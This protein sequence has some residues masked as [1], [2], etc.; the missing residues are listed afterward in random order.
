MEDEMGK[1][2]VMET[3]TQE[4][5]R[6][7]LDYD[8]ATGFFTWRADGKGWRG[9]RKGAR[10]GGV[11]PNGYR[12]IRID[13]VDYLA[14]RLAWFWTHNE[15]PGFLRFEDSDKDNC[16]INNLRDSQYVLAK[17]AKHNWRTKEGRS[18][19][20]REY[21][22]TIQ[23]RL[24]DQRF[25]EKFGI[26]LSQYNT[27]HADQDGKCA[28]CGNPETITRNGNVRMLA[29]DHC[30]ETGKVRGL[31][32]G[33][34]NPMIGYAKDSIALLEAAITYLEKH[35]GYEPVAMYAMSEI[36]GPVAGGLQ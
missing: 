7:R 8:P 19:Q 21:R 32:C 11:D 28:I 23:D 33:T 30:H 17:D 20:Q 3:V 31:L 6:E 35:Q 9:I 22:A 13:G 36:N 24:R 27:M 16:A 2:R 26:T 34:C 25:R 14:Q 15:W 5:L 18:A 1:K 4:R 10:A 12:Y 29:V